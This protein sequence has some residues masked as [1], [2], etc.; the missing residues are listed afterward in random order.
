MARDGLLQA[1]SETI[2]F[3]SFDESIAFTCGIVRP[4]LGMGTVP[5]TTGPEDASSWSSR[6]TAGMKS[7]EKSSILPG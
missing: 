2:A 1:E 5:N 7:R 6:F 4:Y 3:I